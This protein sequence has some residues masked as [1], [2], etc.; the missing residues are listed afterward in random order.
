MKK[1]L[2]LFIITSAILTSCTGPAKINYL[3]LTT[4]QLQQIGITVSGEGVFFKNHNP[5]AKETDDKYPWFGFYSTND[6]YL[7]TILYRETDTLHPESKTDSLFVEMKATDFDFYPILIGNPHGIYS[8]KKSDITERLFP[9]AIK[10]SGLNLP[11]RT[12]TLVVWFKP[13]ASLQKAFGKTLR[14]EDYLA[15][16]PII[17]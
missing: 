4:E 11:R 9:V 8:Y 6:I 15:V 7:N 16:P 2:A 1:I 13:T 14:V 5:K 12:D 3:Y 10:M 17:K